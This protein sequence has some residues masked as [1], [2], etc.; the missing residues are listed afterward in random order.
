LVVLLSPRSSVA[1]VHASTTDALPADLLT[2]QFVCC[3]LHLLA[4]IC[5]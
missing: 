2:C 3:T 4:G 1:P 5:R